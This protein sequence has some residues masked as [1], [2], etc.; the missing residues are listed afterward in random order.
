MSPTAS[1]L[2]ALTPFSMASASSPSELSTLTAA[3]ARG[4]DAAWSAFHREFGPGLFRY[5][6]AATRGDYDTASEALQQ[7]YLRVAR[8]ARP[9]ASQVQFESWLRLLARS[10]LND[11]RRRRSV[12]SRL[13]SRPESAPE[14]PAADSAHEQHLA[15]ALESALTRLAPEDRALLEQKYYAGHDVR[16]LAEKLGLTPKAVE[17]RLTRA[18]AELRR[19]LV[20]ALANHE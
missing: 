19:H 9:C 11:H 10:A 13:L 20:A 1:T 3:L 15:A 2:H 12:W 17:S 5:L 6:L 16:T 4:D 14:D 18:R 7:T 8:H